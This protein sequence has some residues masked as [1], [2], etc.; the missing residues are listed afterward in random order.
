MGSLRDR[1]A[2]GCDRCAVGRAVHGTRPQQACSRIARTARGARAWHAE[3]EHGTRSESMARG[4]NRRYATKK[5]GVWHVFRGLKTHGYYHWVATRPAWHSEARNR[6]SECPH[7]RPLS[8]SGRGEVVRFSACRVSCHLAKSARAS[9]G[10]SWSRSSW[11][12]L[13]QQRMVGRA[14][15]RQLEVRL[16]AAWAAAGR[17]WRGLR[18][19]GALPPAGPGSPCARSITSRGTPASRATWMP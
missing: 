8:R 11:R 10:V 19:R 18:R 9:S 6:T 15:E 14:E 16:L 2:Y 17:S 1:G 4:V 13:V 5:A 12:M 3:R 7:P